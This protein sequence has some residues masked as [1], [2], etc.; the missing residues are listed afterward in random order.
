MRGLL[1]R[2][3][4]GVDEEQ[5]ARDLDEKSHVLRVWKGGDL[6]GFSTLLA[7]R[8]VVDGETVEHP[9]LGRHDHVA[10][11]LEF[12][13]ACARLDRDGEAHPGIAACG[14]VHVVAAFGGIPDVSDFCRFS[15]ANFW[16]RFDAEMPMD[17]RR[18]RDAIAR[19]RFGGCYDSVAGV[20]R[21]EAAPLERHAGGSAGRAP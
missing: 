13:D 18:M 8:G 20:V 5:F 1:G 10:G 9:L 3:F 15:G 7:Y 4:D 12:A 21:F 17:I 6:V 16:P 2:H 11:M 19:E 14:A